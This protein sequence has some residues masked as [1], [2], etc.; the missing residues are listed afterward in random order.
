MSEG[1]SNWQRRAWTR[2][3]LL[4]GDASAA[5]MERCAHLGGFHMHVRGALDVGSRLRRARGLSSS[6]PSALARGERDRPQPTARTS[7]RRAAAVTTSPC[8]AAASAALRSELNA[9]T[10]YPSCK[11]WWPASSKAS[12]AGRRITE[13]ATAGGRR[14]RY[15]HHWPTNPTQHARACVHGRVGRRE[16]GRDGGRVTFFVQRVCLEFVA[17]SLV[18]GRGERTRGSSTRLRTATQ[19]QPCPSLP[20]PP[21]SPSLLAP[22]PTPAMLLLRRLVVVR[23]PEE[24]EHGLGHQL[25][26]VCRSAGAGSE[27]VGLGQPFVGWARTHACLVTF[28]ASR[29]VLLA[30]S[31]TLTWAAEGPDAAAA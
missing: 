4:A 26:N 19:R 6:P 9:I 23:C 28:S 30:A 13:K 10:G 27:R 8:L 1:A 25:P 29:M 31:R 12:R 16:G 22:A 14:P 7:R 15:L 2:S 11:K 3:V 5:A 18:P 20:C 21:S 24:G 17:R